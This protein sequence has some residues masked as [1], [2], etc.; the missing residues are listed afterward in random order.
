MLS[1][2]IPQIREPGFTLECQRPASL[3]TC[4]SLATP[5]F[6]FIAYLE[7]FNSSSRRRSELDR[8]DEG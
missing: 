4:D 8:V 2:W 6:D 1:L 5:S 3:D 7:S